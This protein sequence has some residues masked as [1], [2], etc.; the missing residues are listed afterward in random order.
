M[1]TLPLL[2]VAGQMA[3]ALANQ[4]AHGNDIELNPAMTLLIAVFGPFAVLGIKV[5]GAVA[6][7]YGTMALDRHRRLVTWLAV[8][9]FIG[10]G[11]SLLATVRPSSGDKGT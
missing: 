4:L 7:G 6:L 8:A 9:G 2:V 11:V 10:A 1:L 3:D 5:V